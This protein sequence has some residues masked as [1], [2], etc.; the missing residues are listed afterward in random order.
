[1]I[2]GRVKEEPY[3]FSIADQVY[4]SL[5][6]TKF[7]FRDL[8]IVNLNREDLVSVHLEKA[9]EQ[10]LDLVRDPKRIWELKGQKDRQSESQIQVFLTALTGLRAASWVG[11]P[12]PDDEFSQPEL[13]IKIVYQ[14]AEQNRETEIK[15][16]KVTSANQHAGISS[17]EDGVFLLDNEQY[18]QLNAPLT[19]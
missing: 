10:P 5:P 19:R 6:K 16:A 17:D 15:F 12:R 2:Y 4:D 11:D 8:D 18:G 13:A 3:I 1:V 14:S 7:S 9:G